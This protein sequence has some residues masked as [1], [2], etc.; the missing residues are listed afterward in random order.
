ME[1][2]QKVE[3]EKAK[4]ENKDIKVKVNTLKEEERV[5]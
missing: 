5:I 2:Q 3:V 4:N 1:Y